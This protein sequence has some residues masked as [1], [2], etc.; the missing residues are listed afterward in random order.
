MSGVG[1]AGRETEGLNSL[2]KTVQPYCMEWSFGGWQSWEP[3]IRDHE[4]FTVVMHE[5]FL[6]ISKTILIN[7]YMF[8]NDSKCVVFETGLPK[9]QASLAFH[10]AMPQPLL[11][12]NF[13]A[14]TTERCLLIRCVMLTL[15]S[16][17]RAMVYI[18]QASMELCRSG[19]PLVYRDLPACLCLLIVG[20]KGIRCH[21]PACSNF[22]IPS[23]KLD[24]VFS[25]GPQS[26]Y[27][28]QHQAFL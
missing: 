5:P 13:C 8:L 21:H 28:I 25:W 1:V 11:C 9:A 24:G 16:V 23:Y 10:I 12:Q 17:F 19:C 3:D 22:L 6:F 4:F 27:S 15:L 7:V 18:A 14:A 26:Y 20:I 2:R